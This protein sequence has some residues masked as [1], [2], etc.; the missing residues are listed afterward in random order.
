M[1][2]IWILSA[3]IMIVIT[4]YQIS[5]TYAKFVTEINTQ[6]QR[7]VGAWVV[8]VNDT[9]ISNG[10]ANQEFNINQLLYDG[11]GNVVPGKLAPGLEGYFD[12]VIDVTDT[13]VAVRYDIEIDFGLLNIDDDIKFT[14]IKR[15]V[16]GIEKEEGITRTDETKYSG[17]ISLDEITNDKIVTIRFYLKW[18]EDETEEGNE[19]DSTIGTTWVRTIDI[20]VNIEVS[21]YFGE[22]IEEYVEPD[23]E[24]NGG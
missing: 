12:L 6:T 4:S 3:I 24:Q 18:F 1:K 17:T 10:V 22:E 2:R 13:S 7:N 9:N 19:G 14:S 11:N 23:E 5:T 21:Q 15:I 20:P 16:D 8:K